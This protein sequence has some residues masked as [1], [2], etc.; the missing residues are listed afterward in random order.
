MISNGERFLRYL[1]AVDKTVIWV[2]TLGGLGIAVF[3]TLSM[4][5][6]I[7]LFVRFR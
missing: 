2:C 5:G 6:I 7:P 4:F 1:S 3:E